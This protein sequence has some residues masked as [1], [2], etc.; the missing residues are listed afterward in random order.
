METG[1]ST[2]S[3]RDPRSGP[4]PASARTA[5]IHPLSVS[6]LPNEVLP[7]KGFLGVRNEG[8]KES[9]STQADVSHIQR[10]DAE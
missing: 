7:D 3:Q 8:A 9:S 6:G 4:C 5:Q 10:L 1:G 2:E